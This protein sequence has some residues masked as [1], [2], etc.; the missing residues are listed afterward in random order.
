MTCGPKRHRRSGKAEI[1]GLRTWR[2]QGRVG[3]GT[4]PLL[5]GTDA[6]VAPHTSD[7]SPN[8]GLLSDPR[9][10]GLGG[11]ELPED[12]EFVCGKG[13]IQTWVL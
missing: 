3:G 6:A 4:E 1:S 2:G 13:R 12:K 8:Q 10:W 7:L 9:S 11:C 5:C